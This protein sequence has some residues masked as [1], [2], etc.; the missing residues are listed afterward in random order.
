M[1]D[2]EQ[3]LAMLRAEYERWQTLL[4]SLDETQITS[5]TLPADLSI[6]D[7]VGHLHAWQ[8]ISLARLDAAI[9]GREPVLPSW[10]GGLEP[11]A[12]EN[13]EQ[14][15]AAIH[16]AWRDQPWPLVYGAWR[17]GFLRLLDLGAAIPESDLFD[18][19][20]YAWLDGYALADVLHGSYDHHHEEHYKPLAA[21]LR[22]NGE[23][24]E[25][26]NSDG[27]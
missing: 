8:Q 9:A 13:L 2:K 26:T 6:K 27:I 1:P 16:A 10:L 23:S 3:L 12:E 4:G 24:N 11:D 25:G 14:I 5:R 21:W 17:T 20:R 15:N 18:T 7:V 19:R 22:E